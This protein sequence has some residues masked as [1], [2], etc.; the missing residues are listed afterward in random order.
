MPY[1]KQD[2]QTIYHLSEDE[3]NQ[4]LTAATLPLDKES[5]SDEEIQSSFEL[6]RSYFNSGQVT[7]YEAASQ[8]FKQHQDN[9]Q[10]Q[11]KSQTKTKKATKG[12]KAENGTDNGT[13]QNDSLTLLELLSH[14]KEQEKIGVTLSE[15]MQIFATCGLSDQDEYTFEECDRF[16]EACKLIKKQNKSFEEVA[17]H[18]GQ[19]SPGL[20]L[21]ADMQE[22]LSM[23]G[24]AAIATEEDLLRILNELTAKRGQAISVM[25]ERMLLAQVASQLR[26]RQ[27]KRQF[28]A[29]FGEQLEA[30]MEGK[31]SI[32]QALPAF[33]DEPTLR[34]LQESSDKS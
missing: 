32:P 19:T 34:S 30:F 25:Y 21:K 5:Y 28:F 31:S 15:A 24:S 8:L 33:S 2:L 1:V 17:A 16:V 4:T 6:V 23:V 9:Q 26:E 13:V 27:Q 11:E 29:Q 3:V 12:K 22:I 20:N 7:D 14:L 18:F 10:P